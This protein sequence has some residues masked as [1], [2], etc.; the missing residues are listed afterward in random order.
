MS[1]QNPEVEATAILEKEVAL[2]R[3][4]QELEFSQT[5][6][7][8]E[9]AILKAKSD[10]EF[11][12]TPVGQE[13]Q[14]FQTN[15]RMGQM[16]A[17][18]T[19]VP[20]AYKGNIANC[21]IAC[22]VA[23]RMKA[24]ALMVMQ[25]LYLVHGNPSWSSK[26]LIATINTCGR[27]QPLRYESN[28]KEGDE[29]GW[30][31][32]TYASEDKKK[33]ERLEGPWVTW[34]M[35]KAEGWDEKKGSKWKTMPEQMFRYRAAAFWQ[36]LYAP[37]ISMGFN[38]IEESQEMIEDVAYTEIDNSGNEIRHDQSKHTPLTARERISAMA[39]QRA[40]AVS[41]QNDLS[42]INKDSNPKPQPDEAADNTGVEYVDPQTGEIKEMT[43]VD[44]SAMSD[45]EYEK[46]M[47][48]IDREANYEGSQETA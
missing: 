28:N 46:L 7:G 10:A 41:A 47:E 43:D 35:V 23:L 26:F 17:A 27:F 15:Q 37:E 48:S 29:Y 30:R 12:L 8:K 40:K 14:R 2:L 11:A 31:C 33:S 20:D 32:Y 5:P 34:K 45:E 18:S 22:D 1:N 39:R 9:I 16:Y 4:K 38:T 6:A 25:N 13:L 19:I 3:Q 21:A 36:R 24:N 42:E 44:L